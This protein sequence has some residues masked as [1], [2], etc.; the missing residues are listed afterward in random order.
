[1]CKSWMSNDFDIDEKYK[2]VNSY[3][4]RK[5]VKKLINEFKK[6]HIPKDRTNDT[7]LNK[8]MN[9]SDHLVLVYSVMIQSK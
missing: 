7:N 2:R 9:A 6:S 3:C 5:Y 8:D 4:G 1:M